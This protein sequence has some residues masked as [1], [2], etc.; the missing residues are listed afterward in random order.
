MDRK[1]IEELLDQLDPEMIEEA[2]EPER[3]R[4]RHKAVRL[5]LLCAAAA[6][7]ITVGVQVWNSDWMKQALFTERQRE[8]AAKYP[9][10]SALGTQDGL[11][12]LV[13]LPSE[14]G[15]QC[16]CVLMEGL[17]P[18]DY[19]PGE[20]FT[21]NRTTV[22]EMKLILSN[23]NISDDRVIIRPVYN[24]EPFSRKSLQAFLSLEEDGQGSVYAAVFSTLFNGQYAV[25][26][27]YL[28]ISAVLAD[29]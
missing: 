25:R 6:V 11:T 16:T 1:T 10:Y 24:G 4:K 19:D 26:N 23:Y 20:L 8:T 21:L 3:F 12:I 29:D 18:E 9:E 7:L 17:F 28:G 2:A 14:N 5:L 13:F 22:E 15:G 27:P